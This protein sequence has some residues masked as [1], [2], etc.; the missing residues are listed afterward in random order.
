MTLDITD[1][2][3]APVRVAD[4]RVV[5]GRAT[6]RRHDV[7]PDFQF[8]GQRYAAPLELGPGKWELRLNAQAQDGTAFAQRLALWVRG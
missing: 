2:S 7:A 4:L 1:R 3:G 6:E 5:V 8:D